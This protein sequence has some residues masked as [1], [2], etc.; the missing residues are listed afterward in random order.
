MHRYPQTNLYRLSRPCQR[1]HHPQVVLVLCRDLKPANIMRRGKVFKIGDFGFSKQFVI[2]ESGQTEA[3]KM[4]TTVGTPLYM[5]IEILK[6]LEYSS[7]CD[8]WALGFIFYEMLHG[9]TPWSASREYELVNNI[10]NIPL[11]IKRKDLSPE[12]VD[13]LKKCLQIYEKER[14][15]WN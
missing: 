10:E 7:K 14:I 11:K 2:H 3:L 1:R 4:K 12:T 9:E 6:S 15:S 13:F 5:S 8:I